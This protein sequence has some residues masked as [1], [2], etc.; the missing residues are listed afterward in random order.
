MK[1]KEVMAYPLVGYEFLKSSCAPGI[2][3]I[4]LRTKAGTLTDTR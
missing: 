2:I 4:V 1:A 3:G